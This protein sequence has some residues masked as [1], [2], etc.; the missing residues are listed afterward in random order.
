[1]TYDEKS[2]QGKR[3]LFAKSANSDVLGH[4]NSF[5]V[6]LGPMHQGRKTECLFSFNKS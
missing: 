3:K 5:P 1:M 6:F 4:W 2:C